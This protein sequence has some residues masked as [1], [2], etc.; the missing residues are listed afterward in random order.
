MTP[1]LAGALLAAAVLLGGRPRTRLG[2][3]GGGPADD[4]PGERVVPS[5][6]LRRHRLVLVT[7]AGLAGPLWLGGAE[8][9]LVGL[10][11]AA[12]CWAG[13]GRAEP[14]AVVR[15]R[16]RREAELPHAV[17]LLALALSAGLPVPEALRQVAAALPGPATRA[18]QTA[19][20]R[21]AVGA[22]PDA[23]WA[24]LVHDPGTARLVRTLARAERTGAAVADVVARLATELAAERRAGLEERARAVGVRAAL[25]LGV[26]LLPAFVLLG[27]APVVLATLSA[28]S[29]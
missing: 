25:P 10:V 16:R 17:L 6:W 2:A 1:L 18:L 29:W 11:V 9:T 24:G 13:I 12:G 21:L 22:S 14:A 26:C 19:A 3:G 15:E 7:G 20:S 23:A 27:V 8:G 28:L 5:W 4:R